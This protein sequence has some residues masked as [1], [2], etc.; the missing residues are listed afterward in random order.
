MECFTNWGV[1]ISIRSIIEVIEA[2]NQSKVQTPSL[3]DHEF[4]SYFARVKGT[5][6]EKYFVRSKQ[7]HA[8]A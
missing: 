3:N 4:V 5:S 7:K 2:S 8:A 1:L 6:R